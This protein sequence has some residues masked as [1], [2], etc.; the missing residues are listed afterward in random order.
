MFFFSFIIKPTR[1]TNFEH[2]FWHETTCFGQFLCPS[3]VYKLYTQQW[4]MSHRF[5]D[6]FRAG[7][8]PARKLSGFYYKE[9]CS[10]ARSYERKKKVFFFLDCWT[11]KTKARRSFEKSGTTRPMTQR[12]IAYVT[13]V[14][15][16][17]GPQH[18]P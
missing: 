3:S 4:Y 8:G 16:Q 6:S 7:P 12:H 2:L 11:L 1:C 15:T 17:W 10:D 13:D 5:V 18:R 14:L 9:I